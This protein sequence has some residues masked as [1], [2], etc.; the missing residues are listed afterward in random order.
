MIRNRL[1]LDELYRVGRWRNRAAL[2]AG[3]IKFSS[4]RR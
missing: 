4:Y 1:V 3:T 2:S